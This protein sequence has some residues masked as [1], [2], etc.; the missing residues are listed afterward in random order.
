LG[1]LIDRPLVRFLIIPGII[2]LLGLLLLVIFRWQA[3]ALPQ[4]FT[5]TQEHS[6]IYATTKSVGGYSQ[7]VLTVNGSETVITNDRFNNLDV[8][9]RGD[10]VV[11]VRELPEE[12]QVVRYQVSSRIDTTLATGGVFERP[13]VDTQGNTVWQWWDKTNSTW[14]IAYYNGQSI[15][16]NVIGLYPD[17]LEQRIIFVRKNFQETWDL[18]EL[19]LIS[20]EEKRIVS[21]PAVKQAWFDDTYAYFPGGRVAF[22]PTPSPIPT[23]MPTPSA[24]VDTAINPPDLVEGEPTAI[25]P[26]DQRLFDGEM[27]QDSDADLE[28]DSN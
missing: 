5:K 6:S 11:W 8:F 24:F 15:T 25:P 7:I 10:Y 17:I 14:K 20:Q 26:G 13:R 21:D 4:I 3:K 18:L 28:M 9:T 2:T 22:D 19:D 16:L 27:S 23:P 12:H 1:K